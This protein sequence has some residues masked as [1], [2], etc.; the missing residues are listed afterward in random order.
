M[1]NGSSDFNNLDKDPVETVNNLENDLTE[2]IDS[3]S[4]NEEEEDLECELCGKVCDDFDS[5]LEHSGMGDCVSYCE[6]CE[7]TFKE[8]LDLKK[9]MEKHCT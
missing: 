4:D 5:Y 3:D 6:H 8:E 1:D 7:K 9:K 2:T